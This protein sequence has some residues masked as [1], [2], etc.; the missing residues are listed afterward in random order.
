MQA[1]TTNGNPYPYAARGGILAAVARGPLAMPKMAMPRENN[2]IKNMA[3][4]SLFN[5]ASSTARL[6]PQAAKENLQEKHETLG[7]IMSGALRSAGRYVGSAVR[8]V[9]K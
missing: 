2:P 7:D 8:S 4:E 6:S 1:N 9:T 3:R 5:N